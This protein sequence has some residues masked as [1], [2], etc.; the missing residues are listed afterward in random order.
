MSL[1]DISRAPNPGCNDVDMYI[2]HPLPMHRG[3][4]LLLLE[5]GVFMRVIALTL[6]SAELWLIGDEQKPIHIM[7]ELVRTR[8]VGKRIFP[9]LEAFFFSFHY[10]KGWLLLPFYSFLGFLYIG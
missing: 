6:F 3:Q 9:Q 10:L 1:R 5:L 8:G 2:W 4:D 7:N